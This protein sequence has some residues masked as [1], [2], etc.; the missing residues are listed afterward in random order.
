MSRGEEMQSIHTQ[1][2]QRHTSSQPKTG[3]QNANVNV[4]PKTSRLSKKA[5]QRVEKAIII[6]D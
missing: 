6:P 2:E 3:I 4:I 1:I 5:H